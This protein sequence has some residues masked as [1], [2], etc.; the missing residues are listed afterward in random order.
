[1]ISEGIPGL[2]MPGFSDSLEEQE[3]KSLARFMVE[4]LKSTPQ[5]MTRQALENSHSEPRESS[6]D[7]F[8]LESVAGV[9]GIPWSMAFMPDG[10]IL[11]TEREGS[12]RLLKQGIVERATTLLQR[13]E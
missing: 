1:M 4:L 11:F 6:K 3:V 13:E 12:V 8:R 5:K 7:V 9:Q 10:G 2:G